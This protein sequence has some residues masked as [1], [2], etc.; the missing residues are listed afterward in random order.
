[1]SNFSFSSPSH[2]DIEKERELEFLT[3]TN[4]I[5]TENKLITVQKC[6]APSS[7]PAFCYTNTKRIYINQQKINKCSN[8]YEQYFGTLKGLNYHE[9]SHILYTPDYLYY[10][11][12]D[13]ERQ[14][15]NLLEDC[16]IENRFGMKYPKA[17]LYFKQTVITHIIQQKIIEPEMYIGVYGRRLFLNKKHISPFKKKFIHK[18]GDKTIISVEKLINEYLLDTTVERKRQ[19]SK[20]I[21][22]LL[23]PNHQCVNSEKNI[24]KLKQIQLSVI[25]N[26][27]S[28][29]GTSKKDKKKKE[30]EKLTEK[31]DS[32][33]KEK[34]KKDDEKSNKKDNESEDYDEDEIYISK[35]MMKELEKEIKLTE[36]KIEKD[37][38]EDIKF[39][40][41][42]EIYDGRKT[43]FSAPGI[44]NKSSYNNEKF[45]PNTKNK[46]TSKKLET[47]IR[48]WKLENTAT[49]QT[50]Q[51]V[52][53]LDLR[54]ALTFQKTNNIKLFKNYKGDTSKSSK[55]LVS[56]LIDESGS[57][58]HQQYQLE[59]A[60]VW[61]LTNALENTGSKV[62]I[63]A[64]S[65]TYKKKKGFDSKITN[66]NRLFEGGT[67]PFDGITDSIRTMYNYS[68]QNKIKNKY[69]IIIT[70]GQ[71]FLDKSFVDTKIKRFGVKTLEILVGK[72]TYT[73]VN[74]HKDLYNDVIVIES[75]DE[76]E[77]KLMNYI[78]KEQISLIKKGGRC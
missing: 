50:N 42:Q 10:S 68:L 32:M 78:K 56:F 23:Y 54:K 69:M 15:C 13:T 52:G 28:Q 35:Q 49:Y 20:S 55:M 58:S 51:K 48:K 14:I 18:F 72:P 70:D 22:E 30:Q 75:F 37:I 40:K 39:I 64:F 8:S 43:D 33:L 38:Q 45:I 3:K 6:D 11:L 12:S 74:S 36:Q 2:S 60:V 67:T 63:H 71:Y 16:R 59:S 66:W 44:N 27:N 41:N 7:P 17:F 24:E 46:I 47:I 19:I 21:T 77:T 62:M 5:L 4:Q 9:L 34:D 76:L 1:M 73:Y 29:H 53:R 61:S 26:T 57:I 31:I 65:S 25:C